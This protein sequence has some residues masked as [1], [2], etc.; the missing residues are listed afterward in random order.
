M[1]RIK[2]ILKY[3]ANLNVYIIFIFIFILFLFQLPLAGQIGYEF[4]LFT[5]FF[6]SI[7]IAVFVSRFIKDKVKF[8][9]AKKELFTSLF[10]LTF[11]PLAAS[12]IKSFF[13]FPCS[14]PDGVLFYLLLVIPNVIAGASVAFIVAWLTKRFRIFLS[15][16]VLFLIALLPVIE[17]YRNP[18]VFFYNPLIGFFPGTIYDEGIPIDVTLIS[19]RF[20][21][22][23]FFFIISVFPFKN[24][25][26]DRIKTRFKFIYVLSLVLVSSLFFYFSPRLG[27]SSD[28]ERIIGQLSCK[29]ETEHFNIY[30]PPDTDEKEKKIIIAEH[31]YYFEVLK[32]Y[33]NSA[34]VKKITSYIFED[35]TQKRT[36]LGAGNADIAKPWLYE[37]YTE[38]GSRDQ[39]LKHEISHCFTGD[40][41]VTPFQIASNFNPALI[42]GIAMAS[43]GTFNGFPVDIIVANAYRT[44]YKVNLG[45]LF[46][47]GLSFFTNASSLS[48]AFAGS[49]VKFIVEKYG[50]ERFKN[51]Y[52]TGNFS[53][54]YK[55][56]FNQVEKEYLEYLNSIKL[57]ENKNRA[58]IYFGGRSIFSKVCPRYAAS[59]SETGWNYYYK[60]DYNEA[61]KIFTRLETLTS[62]YQALTGRTSALQK[63]NRFSDAE[64]IIAKKLPGFKNASS[65]FN[66]EIKYADFLFLNNKPGKADSIYKE[67]LHQNSH[68][69]LNNTAALR[70][71]LL[72]E[73]R[74]KN[75]LISNDY[76]R[77]LILKRLLLKGKLDECLPAYFDL[78][79]NLKI[80]RESTLGFMEDILTSV[81]KNLPGA[82]NL[83]FYAQFSF[84]KRLSGYTYYRLMNYY[85]ENL[86][87]F[88][89]WKIHDIA[90]EVCKQPED[91]FILNNLLEKNWWVCDFYHAR[92]TC[93]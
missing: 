51:L 68:P 8:T 28:K 86:Q 22:A 7:V 92:A 83:L 35:D 9:S 26:S 25:A 88:A 61:L 67:V 36:L 45:N 58:D 60:K 10:I 5:S 6:L 39:T 47:H 11:F 46:N 30:L 37:I 57:T 80:S 59:Q 24:F 71:L 12:L 93:D 15:L 17:I 64:E 13:V 76:S 87:L 90:L 48:Y 40:F 2:K 89:A 34:P 54:S 42:E 62:S 38:T 55:K 66:L 27:Y 50:I 91:I 21:I 69:R 65:Y 19:Y 31:E 23:F 78:C 56:D 73:D 81:K 44:G 20:I 16:V 53:E 33:Y 3:R 70:S 79:E 82:E 84:N 49:F 77:F 72:K 75:Y 85:Y 4:A 74:L 41:G 1:E 32:K 43:E 14:I 29:L 52:S 63:L 18:Q